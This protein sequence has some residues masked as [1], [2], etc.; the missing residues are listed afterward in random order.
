MLRKRRKPEK[1]ERIEQLNAATITG[2]TAFKGANVHG[3]T[4]ANAGS[5]ANRLVGQHFNKQR[6]RSSKERGNRLREKI[7]LVR[8]GSNT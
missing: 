3:A 8:Q 6:L 4:R 2:L 5:N 7:A 1:E